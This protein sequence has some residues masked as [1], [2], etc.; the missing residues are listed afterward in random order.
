MTLTR[1]GLF[2]SG[3]A[4]AATTILK[5]P[6]LARPVRADLARQLTFENLHTGERL[7]AVYWEN[8]AYLPDALQAVNK[9]LRDFRTGDIH[10]IDVRLLE[11]LALVH[12][13]LGSGE[14]FAV[15]R[16]RA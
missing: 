13:R 2:V 8:G 1:R 7:N 14:P 4:L 12:R 3:A 11:L 16:N 6:A 15:I 5:A 10:P 9:V